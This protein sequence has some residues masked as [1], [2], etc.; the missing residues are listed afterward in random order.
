[1]NVF[2]LTEMHR[3][4]QRRKI[5]SKL[6]FHLKIYFDTEAYLYH[7]TLQTMYLNL[8]HFKSFRKRLSTC[9]AVQKQVSTLI[10]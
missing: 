10:C 6:H 2:I 1:M 8:E 7:N 9:S 3:G 4:K 5:V